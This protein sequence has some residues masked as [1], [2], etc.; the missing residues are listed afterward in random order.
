MGDS[1]ENTINRRQAIKRAAAVGGAAMWTTPAVLGLTQQ[2][3]AA[4]T[5][6]FP[7]PTISLYRVP[8]NAQ[9]YAQWWAGVPG[10]VTGGALVPPDTSCLP[11]TAP[12]SCLQAQTFAVVTVTN[13]GLCG[14]LCEGDISAGSA[15]PQIN[16]CTDIPLG[17]IGGLECPSQQGGQPCP[18]FFID[19]G[20]CGGTGDPNIVLRLTMTELGVDCEDGTSWSCAPLVA[21]FPLDLSQTCPDV[22]PGSI[23]YGPGLTVCTE[24]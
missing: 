21:D 16:L 18:P 4:A 14:S 10:T 6:C 20:D 2:P 12:S 8:T 13:S 11:S 15:C 23:V 24:I 17:S 19:I 1:T 5:N 22:I 7:N 3:A 9:S